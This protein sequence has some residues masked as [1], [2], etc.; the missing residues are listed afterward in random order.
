[1][2]YDEKALIHPIF[3]IKNENNEVLANERRT[4]K[5]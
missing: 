2:S 3:S 4:K 5:L 1:M